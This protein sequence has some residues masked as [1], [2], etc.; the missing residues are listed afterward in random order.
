MIKSRRAIH[1]AEW[2]TQ[3]RSNESQRVLIEIAEALLNGV[4][5]FD[6]GVR[7][8]SVTACRSLDDFPSFIVGGQLRRS[9]IRLHKLHI[10]CISNS[11]VVRPNFSRLRRM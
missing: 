11:R 1:A 9:H 4:Q 7:F 10:E 3:H 8:A 6:E 5:G 2:H